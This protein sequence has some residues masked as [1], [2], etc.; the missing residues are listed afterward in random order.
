MDKNYVLKVDEA[1]IRK[2]I[3]T[4][5]ETK[6]GKQRLDIQSIKARLHTH[7][8]GHVYVHSPQSKQD[9]AL[10]ST[11][12][13]NQPS[14]VGDG[15]HT[16][17]FRFVLRVRRKL[18][19]WG[20]HKITHPFTRLL[21]K[22]IPK[23]A[24]YVSNKQDKV[25]IPDLIN[26]QD[27]CFLRAAYSTLL[28]REPDRTGFD[29]YLSHMR[30]LRLTKLEVLWHIRN[31]SEGRNVGIIVPSLNRKY[32]TR[33]FVKFLCRIPI[34]GYFIRIVRAAAVLPKIH[35]NVHE[36]EQL[37]YATNGRNVHE[38]EQLV[39]A[40]NDRTAHQMNDML[41]MQD[42]RQNEA[43]SAVRNMA[44]A[45][46]DKI[47]KHNQ[48]IS[49]VR[50]IADAN[51]KKITAIT[52]KTSNNISDDM[53]LLFEDKFRGAREEI[54][55]RLEPYIH[56]INRN[57]AVLDIGCGRG[58]WLEILR[59]NGI[60]AM[61]VDISAAMVAACRKSGLSAMA[62]DAFEYLSS[63]SADSIGCVSGFH[64]VEHLSTSELIELLVEIHRVL[65]QKGV[66]ILETPNP[67]NIY[68]AACN[69]YLDPSHVK[70]IPQPALQFL[71]ESCG[72]DIERVI[73]S[74]RSDYLDDIDKALSP[75]LVELFNCEQDY[76]IIATKPAKL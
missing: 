29:I 1:E 50:G 46:A 34:A 14:A 16:A 21:M 52:K 44:D 73:R 40:T 45:N 58:E 74:T 35:H 47:I 31:S 24:K 6:L 22:L 69:F 75:K 27:E 53:Y 56:F 71:C 66:L 4:G 12:H 64:I 7:A 17:F 9:A 10:I 65:K 3:K 49:A 39:Y 48:A 8:I 25:R 11:D 70:P 13:N 72:F 32:R 59:D 60:S 41:I 61:G 23:S 43:L 36:L 15:T 26:L 63:L 51:A 28:K 55:N 20:V 62:H 57:E 42:K 54:K 19:S 76:A 38:L 18:I 30:S 37:I 5:I 67:E 2:T 33:R 68:M